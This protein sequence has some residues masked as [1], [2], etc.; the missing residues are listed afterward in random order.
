MAAGLK[1]TMATVSLLS[2]R[3][4]QKTGAIVDNFQFAANSVHDVI[5]AMFVMFPWAIS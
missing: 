5:F 3:H 4:D 2:S 1:P